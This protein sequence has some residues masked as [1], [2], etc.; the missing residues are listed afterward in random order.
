M[1]TKTHRITIKYRTNFTYESTYVAWNGKPF[2]S[3]KMWLTANILY[4]ECEF[5]E[6]NIVVRQIFDCS[7]INIEM[8]WNGKQ[9]IL[10]IENYF[11]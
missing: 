10:H 3:H 2:K 5:V 4:F 11:F 8:D 1:Q 9:N 6:K 7:V